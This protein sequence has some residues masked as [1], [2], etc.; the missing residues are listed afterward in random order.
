MYTLPL[1][2]FRDCRIIIFEGGFWAR[3]LEY[4][5]IDDFCYT[6]I[7]IRTLGHILRQI[8]VAKIPISHGGESNPRTSDLE[9]DTLAPYQQA[10]IKDRYRQARLS[11]PERSS[12]VLRTRVSDREV[13]DT[14]LLTYVMTSLTLRSG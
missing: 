2:P 10:L 4:E 1:Q 5:L 9:S 11:Y 8:L 3:G 7:V 14:K 6:L 13:R 12:W